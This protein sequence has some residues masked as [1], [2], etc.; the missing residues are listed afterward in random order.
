[1]VRE[2]AKLNKLAKGVGGFTSGRVKRISS[3]RKKLARSTVELHQMQDL[4]GC[5]AILPT[6][7]D[8]REVLSKYQSEETGGNVRRKTDYIENPKDS[9]YRSFESLRVCRRPST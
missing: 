4:V 2:R 6:M 1:M 9:G 7:D 5:R 8:L 3:I